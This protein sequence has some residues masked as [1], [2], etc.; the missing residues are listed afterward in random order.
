M[1]AMQH[2]IWWVA[3]DMFLISL[4]L[5]FLLD[6]FISLSAYMVKMELCFMGWK[7]EKIRFP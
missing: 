1:I 4:E 3:C 2:G 7:M 6:T 5:S